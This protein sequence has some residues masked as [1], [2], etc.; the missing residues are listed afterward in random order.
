MIALKAQTFLFRACP[1]FPAV[2]Y[3]TFLYTS[4]RATE[5]WQAYVHSD[6]IST[7][8]RGQHPEPYDQNLTAMH[9]QRQHMIHASA[10]LTQLYLLSAQCCAWLYLYR[11]HFLKKLGGEFQFVITKQI[12]TSYTLYFNLIYKYILYYITTSPYTISY[13]PYYIIIYHINYAKLTKL[14]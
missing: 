4:T 14:L 10:H 13:I 2:L 6:S 3:S 8:P 12:Y 5:K 7:D 11:F 9:S 1:D